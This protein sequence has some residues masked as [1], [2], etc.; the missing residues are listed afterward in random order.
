MMATPPDST[1]NGIAIA[2]VIITG[3]IGG[4]GLIWAILAGQTAKRALTQANIANRLS[5]KANT[6]SEEANQIATRALMLGE[7]QSKVCIEIGRAMVT[8]MVS[9]PPDG[10]KSEG[11]N[12]WAF[13][14]VVNKG[15]R[16]FIKQA[17]LQ[18]ADEGTGLLGSLG[19]FPDD[20]VPGAMYGPLEPGES[21]IYKI[22][23]YPKGTPE[24]EKLASGR[25]FVVETQCGARAEQMIDKPWKESVLAACAHNDEMIQKYG[26]DWAA[27]G[28]AGELKDDATSAQESS[29]GISPA[30]AIR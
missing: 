7:S 29:S 14:E 16:V 4:A 30:S 6:L 21:R 10:G 3:L 15:R 11:V 25:R 13:V 17:Y 26:R 5:D 27:K 9:A 8:G 19:L 2:G 23:P 22:G 1:T 12:P 20:G 28:I 18:F 24:F